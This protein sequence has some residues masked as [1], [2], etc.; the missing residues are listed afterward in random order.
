M[1]D[2]LVPYWDYTANQA[3][4]PGN[5]P[6]GSNECPAAIQATGASATIPMGIA[7]RSGIIRTAR[8]AA[9]TPLGAPDTFTVDIRKNGTTILTAPIALLSSTGARISVLGALAVANTPVAAGDFFE[10]VF[11][12]GHTTG[13]APANVIAQV[14]L[15]LN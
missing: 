3:Q 10:A 14:D 7:S 8:I 13:T 2:E 5:V 4:G 11:T 9:I 1:A 15:V 12:Y 6:S